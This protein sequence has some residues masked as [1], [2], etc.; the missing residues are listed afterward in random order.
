[1]LPFLALGSAITIVWIASLADRRLRLGL[2][3]AFAV[4]TA[5]AVLVNC[6]I[7]VNFQRTSEQMPPAQHVAWFDLAA[8]VDSRG[9]GALWDFATGWRRYIPAASYDS[10]NLLIDK[11]PLAESANQP[12]VRSLGNPPFGAEYSVDVPSAGRYEIAVRYASERS[13][14]V[15]LLL[16]GRDVAEVCGQPTGGWYHQNSAWSP[17]GPFHPEAGPNK[18]ALLSNGPV[19]PITMLRV[20]RVR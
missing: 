12:I 11:G 5:Y 15:R 1:M 2:S 9:P 20:V 8:S 3:A 6:A 17:A 19:P 7:A 16:N 13:W 4:A 14:P 10:G 18:I